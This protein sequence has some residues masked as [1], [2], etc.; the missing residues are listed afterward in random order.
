M[1]ITSELIVRI[2]A[3][4]DKYQEELE[5]V[6]KTTKNLEKQLATV[7]K[8]SG[9][10]FAAGTAAIAGATVAAGKFEDKFTNVVT[11]LDESSF[12]SKTLAEGINGLKKGVLELGQETGESFEDLNTALFDLISA[13]VPAEEA[14]DTLR[15]TTELAA[16]GATTTS[17]AVK[18]LTATLTAFGDSAGT[19]SEISEKFFTAQKFGVT[20]V[21]ELATEFSKV[22]GTANSLG[23]SFD[24]TLA[25][26]SALTADGSKQTNVA[27]TQLKAAFTSIINIQKDLSKESA[28]VQDALDLQNVKQRGLVKTLDLLKVATGGNIPEMQRLLG[29]AESLSVALSLTGAQ[30]G[31]VAKQVKEMGDEQRRAAVFADALATKQENSKRA[32]ER[33]S[34][35]VETGAIVIGEQFAP[36]LAKAAELLG[37]F[38]KI[39]VNNPVLA[40][41]TALVL[42]L[43]TAFAGIAA[44]GAIAATAFLK[45]RA[46]MIALNITTK[47][48]AVGVKGLVGATGIGLLV[49]VAAE[50]LA[51]WQ[52]I[53]P[54]VVGI[55]S[56]TV[57]A[58]SK[59]GSSLGKILKGIFT[60][61]SKAISEGM[62]EAKKAVTDGLDGVIEAIK[63][64]PAIEEGMKIDLKV[65][66]DDQQIK[67]EIKKTQD[68]VKKSAGGDVTIGAKVS[69][70]GGDESNA[71]DSLKKLKDN[72]AKKTEALNQEQKK[73]I[74]QNKAALDLIENQNA[75]ASEKELEFIKRKNELSIAEEKAAQE[76]NKQVRES[77]LEL[78][79]AQK[80]QL[81]EEERVF[82]EEKRLVQ[83]EDREAEI[84]LQEELKALSDEERS[85]L[86]EQELEQIRNQIKS[87]RE[88]ED[89]EAKEKLKFEID[90]RNKYLQDE[91]RHGKL[92]AELNKVLGSQEVLLAKQT[93]NEL[94]GLS[95]SK[96]KTLASIGKAASLTQIAIDTATSA[97]SI[98]AKLNALFPILAPG[99]GFAGAAAIT[100]FGAEKTAAVLA[101]NEGG[102]VPKDLGIPGKDSVPAT[103]TPGEL[104][105]PT[106]NFDEVI[107]SV[108]ASRS[109]QSPGGSSS[110]AMVALLSSINQKLDK[111]ETP[112][113]INGDVVENETFVDNLIESIRDARDFRNATLEG[114]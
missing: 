21:G 34:R 84:A 58:L 45:I 44:A 99:I 96:N 83:A 49:I 12:A 67:G 29:S 27:A 114:L 68:E 65:E 6:G 48:L 79:Q 16:A 57:D 86:N 89:A 77:E 112:I 20:T 92:V 70:S 46:A 72:E 36:I 106:K 111:L 14:I 103:L 3:N 61:D 9:V 35:V 55:F 108:S 66:S 64:E 8:I 31:L 2:G 90:R 37:E 71:D 54:K 51:N 101:A 47:L 63:K 41:T 91:K 110:P 40:K 42:G 10:A 56:A 82:L 80:E 113:T 85:A 17:I 74:A 94:V 93:A 24:E 95:Q 97:A 88:I 7:A 32:F 107:N 102:I 30:S 18:A 11:L 5:K 62:D 4:A 53:W 76:K 25:S 87:K 73:R 60:L 33:F 75:G 43:G 1:A 23:I 109:G 105:V 19:A 13:G 100:A 59:L 52:T 98:F 26:L 69:T 78:I 22:A 50:I 81:L 28:E 39:L 15:V 104:V 38:F